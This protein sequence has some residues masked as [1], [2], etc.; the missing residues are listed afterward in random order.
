MVDGGQPLWL[1]RYGLAGRCCGNGT[2]QGIRDAHGDDKRPPAV[3]IPTPV[4]PVPME[5]P[6]ADVLP[7]AMLP[8]VDEARAGA[9]LAEQD[10]GDRKIGLPRGLDRLPIADIVLPA[11]LSGKSV[12][13]LGRM[14]GQVLFEAERRGAARVVGGDVNAENVATYRLLAERAGS[15]AEFAEFDVE[16]DEIPGRFDIVLCLGVLNNLRNPLSALEKLIAATREC[17][18]L[19]LAAFSQRT[20]AGSSI[21]RLLGRAINRL[22]ILYLGRARRNAKG[23]QSFLM[24]ERAVVALLNHHRRDFARVRIVHAAGRDGQA[25][26]RFIAI[27][28]KRRIGH[29]YILAGTNAIGKTTLIESFRRGE[30]LDF[31]AQLGLDLSL[32]WRHQM[33]NRLPRAEESDV[34]YMLLEYNIG[35]HLFD[36]AL[37]HFER[38]VLDLVKVADKVSIATFWHRPEVLRKRYLTERVPRSWLKRRLRSLRRRKMQI[39]LHDL[40]G[41]SARFEEI[42]RHWFAF[43]RRQAATNHVI[44]QEN[45]Y[46][47]VSIEDWERGERE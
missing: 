8:Q 18:I 16:R 6:P 10:I 45:G 20:Q 29:L 38:G 9:M 46:R 32:G 17:L 24:T 35:K 3:G 25:A 47:V 19:E 42:Y 2:P 34:P 11:D 39:V 33:Y 15:R 41:D 43:A 40:Y 26:G 21:P 4:R 37:D 28:P 5:H 23:G 44:L 27:A 31:A 7:S 12:F 22:P 36:G 30:N 13:G 14:H 1:W